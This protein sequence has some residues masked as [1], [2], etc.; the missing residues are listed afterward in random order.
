MKRD[1]RRHLIIDTNVLLA[2]VAPTSH[3]STE[4]RRRSRDLLD[5]VIKHDWPLLRLYTPNICF[6]EAQC[7][8]DKFG[9]CDWHG[10][11]NRRLKPEDYYSARGRLRELVESRMIEQYEHDAI[12]FACT[13]LASPVNAAHK[14][15]NDTPP[16][17]RPMGGADCAICGLAI[18]LAMRIGAESVVLV[19]ADRRMADVIN[20]CRQMSEMQAEKLG[21]IKV[22]NSLAIKWSNAIYPVCIHIGE[23]PDDELKS[24]FL[25]WPVP[26]RSVRHKE[27]ANL[28]E[29]EKGILV[30]VGSMIKNEYGIGPDS[31]PYTPELDDLQT[32]Y[33]C[34]TGVYMTKAAIARTLLQWR[35]N[36]QRR[37]SP[38]DPL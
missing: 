21:L 8:L 35:K 3:D 10:A 6:A 7:V 30:H 12:S 36:P 2:Y 31:L 18:R 25:G 5:S 23:A 38:I 4:V 22:A 27:P 9:L 28:T 24:A 13:E 33:A 1:P 17:Y 29:R 19:T 26:S 15:I 34:L 20:A 14:I 16:N 11:S 32:R 37:P